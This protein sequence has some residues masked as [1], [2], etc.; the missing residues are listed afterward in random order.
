MNAYTDQA[1]EIEHIAFVNI[2]DVTKPSLRTFRIRAEHH[3]MQMKLGH[4]FGKIVWAEHAPAESRKVVRSFEI[5]GLVQ[6]QRAH[7][8]NMPPLASTRRT[9]QVLPTTLK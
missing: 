1:D 3:G 5:D 7:A 2:I 6:Q 9:R 8:R 4:I